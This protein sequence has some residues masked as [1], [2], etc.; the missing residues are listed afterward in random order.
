MR[1]AR[2]FLLVGPKGA[3][4]TTLAKRMESELG[5]AFVRV[6]AI[7]LALAAEKTL[8][9]SAFD[10]EG[11]R[12]VVGVRKAPGPLPRQRDGGIPV[13]IHQLVERGP[14][15]RPG[16]LDQRDRALLDTAAATRLTVSAKLRRR[17]AR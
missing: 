7:W 17:P 6:E 10:T 4:K 9:G 5:I 16:P 1:R 15:S 11:L 13:P 12:R 3:G 8:Q 2:I 14:G